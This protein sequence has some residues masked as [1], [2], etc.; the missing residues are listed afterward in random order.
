MALSPLNPTARACVQWEVVII[1][2][3]P[4]MVPSILEIVLADTTKCFSVLGFGIPISS[5]E[6]SFQGMLNTVESS[7]RIDD[8]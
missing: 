4:A 5:R 3:G 8:L 2:H 6:L 7:F 1:A